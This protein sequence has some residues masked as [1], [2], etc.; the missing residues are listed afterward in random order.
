MAYDNKD[1]A[2]N[3]VALL[4]DREDDITIRKKTDTV[5]YTATETQDTIIRIIIFVVPCIIILAG[6][7]VWQ[8]RRRRK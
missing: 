7:V 8:I 1:L 3:S 6:I 2:L 5:T 4:T